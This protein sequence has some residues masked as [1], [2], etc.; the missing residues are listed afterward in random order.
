MTDT[1]KARFE[2]ILDAQRR[3]IQYE[4]DIWRER[5]AAGGSEDTID[6]AG[7]EFAVRNLARLDTLRRLVDNALEQLREGTY[8]VCAGCGYEIPQKRLQAVPWSSFCLVCQDMIE[9]TR[10][11]APQSGL[12]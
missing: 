3:Q 11:L 5:Y 10:P 8:G 1:Q 2:I 12:N 6:D 7:G 4:I 9:T